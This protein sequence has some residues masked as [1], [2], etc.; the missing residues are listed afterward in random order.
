MMSFASW[1]IKTKAKLSFSISPEPR[2]TPSHLL[3]QNNELS[4]SLQELS[5]QNL[6]G[7]GNKTWTRKKMKPSFA[8]PINSFLIHSSTKQQS[9]SYHHNKAHRESAGLFRLWALKTA[10][11]KVLHDLFSRSCVG[12]AFVLTPSLAIKMNKNKRLGPPVNLFFHF[13]G[14][15]FR[16]GGKRICSLHSQLWILLN[17]PCNWIF[18]HFPP[19]ATSLSYFACHSKKKKNLRRRNC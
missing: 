13:S 18:S 8:P 1:T 14:N 15:G 16:R 2:Y 3:A 11:I 6:P 5:I 4:F 10:K 7:R 9:N 17:E 12:A 19:L